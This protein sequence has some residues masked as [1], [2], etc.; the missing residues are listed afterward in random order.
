MRKNFFS[1]PD[2]Y[3]QK[4]VDPNKGNIGY[5]SVKEIREYIKVNSCLPIFSCEPVIR[6]LIGQIN[7][8]ISK[9]PG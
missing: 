9:Q 2:V 3:K 1:Q 5:V 7:L 6:I 8:L 4:Y